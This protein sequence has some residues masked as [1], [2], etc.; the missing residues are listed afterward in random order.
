MCQVSMTTPPASCPASPTSRRDL[1]Q[2]QQCRVVE[3]RAGH[4][5]TDR[6]ANRETD[7]VETGSGVR[8]QGQRVAV[9]LGTFE[10]RQPD[11][12]T[13][14]GR[15]AAGLGD[16]LARLRADGLRDGLRALVGQRGGLQQDP[17]PLVGG[18]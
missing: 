4:H 12:L 3:R 11:Q 6:L 18:G 10:G 13:G 8:V 9:E 7:L 2:H 14:P 16:G 1:V 5:H 15:L 17:H